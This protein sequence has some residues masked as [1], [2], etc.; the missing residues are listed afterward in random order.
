MFNVFD[1]P[2]QKRYRPIARINYK[3]FYEGLLY[4]CFTDDDSFKT[5]N[6]YIGY[7]FL[8]SA[9]NIE[10]MLFQNLEAVKI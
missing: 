10:K 1:T 5:F 4:I 2:R 7:L 9:E 8:S 6:S 3:D